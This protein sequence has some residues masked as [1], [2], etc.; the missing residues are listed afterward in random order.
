MMAKVLEE[1]P[2]VPTRNCSTPVTDPRVAETAVAPMFIAVAT[3]LE[4]TDTK[5][6]LPGDDDGAED[7]EVAPQVTKD[8]ISCVVPS[9]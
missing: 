3:P 1:K 9:L 6:V 4:L 2:F 5:L 8:E 7:M